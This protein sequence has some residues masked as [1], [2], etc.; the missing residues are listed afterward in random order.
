MAKQKRSLD[1]FLGIF[2]DNQG[3]FVIAQ[4]PN[5]PIIVWALATIVGL[6]VDGENFGRALDIIALTSLV[7]WALLEIFRGV[8]LFRRI[9]GFIVLTLLT[10]NSI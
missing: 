5:L 9:L 10:I 8:N 1:K 4:K 2:K 3:K 6:V 7:Y